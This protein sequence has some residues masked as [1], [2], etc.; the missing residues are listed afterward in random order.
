MFPK[1][2]DFLEYIDEELGFD[3]EIKYPGDLEV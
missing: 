2:T 1:L 3:I